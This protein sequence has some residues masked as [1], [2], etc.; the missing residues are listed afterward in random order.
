M[1]KKAIELWK[2]E[3]GK[4]GTTLHR[5]L[6]LFFVLISVSLVLIF[7]LLLSMFGINGKQGQMVQNHLDTELAII[8]DR[9]DDNFGRISLGGITIA[10]DISER[11]DEI[12]KDN[13]IR[14]SELQERPE[15][16]EPLIG[17]QMQTLISTITVSYTHLTLPTN[18]NV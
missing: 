1:L 14:A 11:C 18:V 6:L 12:F 15:L 13:N 16:L 17:D 7:T 2:K 5:R 3:R 8:H 10:E 9:I 4:K